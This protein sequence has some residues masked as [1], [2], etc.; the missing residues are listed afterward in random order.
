MVGRRGAVGWMYEVLISLVLLALF[1]ITVFLYIDANASGASY[2]SKFYAADLGTTAD[3]VNA[4]Y[5]D[6]LLRYDNLKPNLELAFWATTNG[7][8]AVDKSPLSRTTYDATGKRVKQTTT[9][10]YALPLTAAKQYYGLATPFR[11]N[12]LI[13]PTY[14][15]LRKVDGTF[16]LTEAE[17]VMG[18]CPI[19]E[20]SPTL[21][22]ATVNLQAP[23]N[24]RQAF[25]DVLKD[26]QLI[27]TTNDLATIKIHL[28][29]NGN[30]GDTIRY[31]GTNPTGARFACLFTQKLMTQTVRE[32]TA[33]EPSTI[34]DDFT[35]RIELTSDAKQEDIGRSLAFALAEVYG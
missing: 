33:N 5:G 20:P 4:G 15:A 34:T 32:Y 6:V 12:L 11:G 24:V 21:Q 35:I 26:T 19:V 25:A 18:T 23:E 10:D 13:N 22:D 28:A 31:W 30:E 8:V 9:A 27:Q 7:L 2:W 16:A 14:I 17:L 3:L 1:A 29:L